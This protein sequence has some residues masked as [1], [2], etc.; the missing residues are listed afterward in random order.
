[1]ERRESTGTTDYEAAKRVLRERLSAVDNGTVTTIDRERLTVAAILDLVR[2]H[3]QLKNHRSAETVKGHIATWKK[4]LGES[5]RALEVTT[6]DVQRVL[7]AW[8]AEGKAPATCNR[9]LSVLRLAYRLAKLRL[10]PAR[11]DFADL[12]LT[13]EGPLGNYMAPDVFAK[14]HAQ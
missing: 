3:Y 1:K 7:E 2:W 13:E 11:L 14:I 9:R 10:D 4:A 12:F 5:G 6:L 8:G